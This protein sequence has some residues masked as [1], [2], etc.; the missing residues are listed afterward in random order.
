MSGPMHANA[1]PGA[2]E[3]VVAM[4]AAAAAEA[5]HA[6]AL[7]FGERRLD[8]AGYLACVSGFARELEALGARGE[9]VATLIGNSIDACIAMFGALAAGAQLVPLN[10]LLTTHEL[11]PIL[12]DAAP[13][14][15]VVDAALRSHVDAAA[16]AA[17]IA[18]II[19]VGAGGRH[20][21]TWPEGDAALP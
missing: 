13:R 3:S 7:V 18:H 17:G 16:R 20:L 2:H 15:L 19:E 21:D 11:E 6:E 5:P 1:L 9:R 8:Y 10:T 4:L 12:L 14:V